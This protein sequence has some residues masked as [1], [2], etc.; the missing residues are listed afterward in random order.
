MNPEDFDV[1]QAEKEVEENPCNIK[2][3]SDLGQFYAVKGDY[4]TAIK[5]YDK[6]L[7]VSED[8]PRAW[9][10]LGHCYFLKK[11]FVKCINAY[12]KTLQIKEESNSVELWY[13]VGLLY[14]MFEE[15]K[16]ANRVFLA[17]LNSKKDFICIPDIH[18]KISYGLIM[19]K[20]HA[21]AIQYLETALELP[22]T[23]EKLK[24]DLFV[25]LCEAWSVL[26]NEE[27]VWEVYE[28]ST[29]VSQKSWKPLKIL[30]WHL[31]CRK[32]FEKVVEMLGEYLKSSN[33]FSELH[34]L[35]AR[36]YQEIGDFENARICYS[37]ALSLS[38]S[39][40]LYWSGAGILYAEKG[41]FSD[42]YECFSK[43]L[44]TCQENLTIWNNIG[45]LYNLCGQKL[46]ADLSFQRAKIYSG[47]ETLAESFSHPLFN[48]IEPLYSQ[49]YS[50]TIKKNN[51]EVLGLLERC[52]TKDIFKVI[53]SS[54]S[55][56]IQTEE[57]G[58]IVV[59]KVS[60]VIRA[61]TPKHSNSVPGPTIIN[62][63]AGM[64]SMPNVLNMASM[65]N[66]P[67]IANMP[68]M[69]N[70]IVPNRPPV[71]IP[72]GNAVKSEPSQQAVMFQNMIMNPLMFYQMLYRNSM[73]MARQTGEDKNVTGD[74]QGA[75]ALLEMTGEN[76]RKKRTRDGEV[77][78]PQKKMKEEEN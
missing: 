12:Q 68:G 15:W 48:I 64:P 46:E 72:P 51:S 39:A 63:M 2:V 75:K 56:E 32:N 26:K 23:S 33:G 66:M 70:F 29:K 11:D 74:D 50:E 30:A 9:V 55:P 7:R 31:F 36:A 18:Y 59:P 65:P 24:Q 45:I 60:S 47:N 20:K 1:E 77:E 21:A 54:K 22:E 25:N 53:E 44:G 52:I 27:K 41:Q 42:A 17:I 16:N 35:L 34:Y 28:K 76:L 69:M 61:S 37:Q 43:A 10:A 40:F 3:L 13:G 58:E 71:G 78:D 38:P 6:I 49:A 5:N 19:E 67:N 57:K 4:S 14:Y 73:N 8:N 62:P